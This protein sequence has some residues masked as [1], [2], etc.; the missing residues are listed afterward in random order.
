MRLSAAL[1]LVVATTLTVLAGQVPAGA[2]RD[3]ALLEFAVAGSES[4]GTGPCWS[5][6]MAQPRAQR[7]LLAMAEAPRSA[8]DVDAAL[9]GTGVTRRDLERL[10]LIRA[11]SKGYLPSFPLFRARDVLRVREVAD[12]YARALADAV[13]RARVEIEDALALYPDP[14]ARGDVA[15]IVLGCFSLDWD[16]LTLSL[17][18][19]Y[20]HKPADRPD[21]RYDPWAM[22]RVPSENGTRYWSSASSWHPTFAVVVFGDGSPAT[23]PAIASDELAK[24]L[25][26]SRAGGFAVP[27]SRGTLVLA[28]RDRPMIQRLLGIGRRTMD[29]WLAANYD[30]LKRELGDAGP[31]QWNVPFAETFTALWHEVFGRANAHLV[32]AGLF[33]DPHAE[34][35]AQRGHVAAVFDP[36]VL[37]K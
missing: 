30:G 26:A 9:A 8:A 1:C 21:G 12:R 34:G 32:E 14:A 16:G 36:V 3:D 15:F 31:G 7:L 20:R 10:R 37:K 19:G 13:L 22:E 27:N 35:R 23:L 18:R 33:A 25:L 11:S 28:S 6:V 17:E 29:S 2:N 5:K 4:C 24:A